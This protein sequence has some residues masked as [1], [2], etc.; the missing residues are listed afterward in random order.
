M[1]SSRGVEGG[2]GYARL[3]ET[4]LFEN[5]CE[6]LLWGELVSCS[7]HILGHK[8]C[9]CAMA[10]ENFVKECSKVAQLLNNRANPNMFYLSLSPHPVFSVLSFVGASSDNFD[11]GD[12]ICLP[13]RGCI[14]ENGHE[15]PGEKRPHHCRALGLFDI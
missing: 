6:L 4:R 3:S 5:G 8:H 10:A 7:S 2:E 9:L 12:C 11:P 1:Q 13:F 14:F 15:L